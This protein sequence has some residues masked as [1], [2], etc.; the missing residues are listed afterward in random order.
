MRHILT[1]ILITISLSTFGQIID[2]TLNLQIDSLKNAAIVSTQDS[3]YLI[4]YTTTEVSSPDD[5]K[6]MKI[7]SVGNQIWTKSIGTDSMDRAFEIEKTLDGGYI[8]LGSSEFW[9]NPLMAR[10]DGNGD[11]LWVKDTFNF[12]S[13][14]TNPIS[15][16]EL[17][18]LPSGDF[19]IAGYVTDLSNNDKG[20]FLAKV[21]DLGDIIWDKTLFGPQGNNSYKDIEI[22]EDGSIIIAGSYESSTGKKMYSFHGLDDFGN[23]QWDS[24]LGDTSTS[25][26]VDDIQLV[27]ITDTSFYFVGQR[28]MTLWEQTVGV[29]DH[30][31]NILYSKSEQ[32]IFWGTPIDLFLNKDSNI[33][34]VLAG[35]D[36]LKVIVYNQLGDTL[37]SIETGSPNIYNFHNSAINQ[38]GQLTTVSV[39]AMQSDIHWQVFDGLNLCAPSLTD[40]IHPGDAN[41]DGVA[42]VH[43]IVPLGYAFGESGPIRINASNNWTSQVGLLWNDTLPNGLDLIHADCNGDG[44]IDASDTVAILNNYGLTHSKGGNI[45]WGTAAS[46]VP[47]YLESSNISAN[48]GDTVV[49]EIKVGDIINGATDVGATVVTFDFVEGIVADLEFEAINSWFGSNS[50]TMSIQKLDLIS[51]KLHVGISRT[52]QQTAAGFGTIGILKAAIGT[53]LAP[54]DTIF[55]IS[56]EDVSVIES[57]MLPVPIDVQSELEDTI[58]INDPVATGIN[59]ASKP[60]NIYPSITSNE[61]NI[62]HQGSYIISVSNINGIPVLKENGSNYTTIDLSRFKTGIYFIELTSNNNSFTQKIIKVD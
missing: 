45:L 26:S 46:S 53:N 21:S 33:V 31:G 14:G 12:P 56:I 16:Q 5:I 60:F 17:F 34:G 52:D 29:I 41:G 47:V 25:A 10:M 22:Q 11:T 40:S 37:S 24:Y 50:N 51:G 58:I 32:Q 48:P 49:I 15:T 35:I 1:I 30:N 3:G 28:A 55:S 57:A 9:N 43:D 4:A 44:F 59:S 20:Q 2:S 6:I 54:E 42:N 13:A 38:K 19:L 27:K 61:V 36:S 23:S 7:D 18:V 8:L 62:Q 39:V